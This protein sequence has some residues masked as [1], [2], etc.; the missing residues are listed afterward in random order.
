M[1]WLI[2]GNLKYDT[3]Q[4]I[5]KDRLTDIQNILVVAQGK[6][7]KEWE[8][9]ISRTSLLITKETDKQQGPTTQHRK[10]YPISYE[11]S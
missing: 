4:R 11:K 9:G 8:F 10:L 1:K 7:G 5:C 2:C 3:S 6:G